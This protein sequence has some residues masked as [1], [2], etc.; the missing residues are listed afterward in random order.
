MNDFIDKIELGFNIKIVPITDL[1][2]EKNC[3][4]KGASGN[5]EKL[6]LNGINLLDLES[7]IPLADNLTELSIE[8]CQIKNLRAIERFQHL[9]KL[10]L[11]GNP[12]SPLEFE[13]LHTL[14][15]LTDLNLSRTPIKDTRPIGSL[16]RLES[17]KI[18]G[19][20][21]LV[22]IEGL[23]ELTNLTTLDLHYSEIN[24]LLKVSVNENIKSIN[25]YGS[26]IKSIEGLDRF[27]NLMDLNIGSNLITKIQGLDNLKN[28]KRL[29]LSSNR[30]KKI[31]GL[32]NL[33]N[34]EI[35][36]LSDLE[37]FK[38]EGLSNLKNLKKIN[39]SENQ[40]EKIDF[41][42][43]LSNLELILLDY[44]NVFALD[45]SIFSQIKGNCTL[46]L[47]ENPIKQFPTN[48]PDHIIIKYEDE[49]WLPR[50]L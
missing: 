31:E 49:D 9:T 21:E 29:N 35:L 36:D 14:Q 17:L 44:N 50:L 5:I 48:I 27:Q 32:E 20:N 23:I 43:S 41:P 40:I 25:L 15:N 46:S 7:L 33:E 39:L 6:S 26:E 47:I 38:I 11:S 10:N 28:L 2:E 4:A 16:K 1:A 3:Y 19:A 34:L 24:T 13:N 12:I 18:R 30:I 45:T 22:E 37:I 42:E 8:D